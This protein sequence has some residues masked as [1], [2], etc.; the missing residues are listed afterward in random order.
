MQVSEGAD[1]PEHQTGAQQEAIDLDTELKGNLTDLASSLFR[2]MQGS[3][4]KLDVIEHERLEDEL[5][6]TQE[7][8]MDT[9]A[10][11]LAQ[12]QS[13]GSNVGG[14]L[15]FVETQS[16]VRRNVVLTVSQLFPKWMPGNF[17][18]RNKTKV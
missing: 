17:S 18:R 8:Y 1:D 4:E 9:Y 6:I 10:L 13:S 12:M 7:D 2:V 14:I 3:S 11:L 16:I 5:R 15:Q